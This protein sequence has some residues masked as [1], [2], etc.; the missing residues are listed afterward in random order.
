MVRL[1]ASIFNTSILVDPS[2]DFII[3]N[4]YWLQGQLAAAI[5]CICLPTLKP[6][7]PKEIFSLA[8][9]RTIYDSLVSSKTR[10]SKW[11]SK[12]GKSKDEYPLSSIDGRRA[13]SYKTLSEESTY[14]PALTTDS[15]VLQSKD[16][17]NGGTFPMQA[18][19]GRSDHEIV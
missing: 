7:L 8:K 3:E 1:I 18:I 2:T 16:P 11:T 5:V 13:E 6:L 15:L 17:D 9:L 4:N 12:A 19:A 14:Q 10:F